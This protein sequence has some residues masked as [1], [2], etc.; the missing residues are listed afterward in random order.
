MVRVTGNS[1]SLRLSILTPP[2]WSVLILP[3]VAVVVTIWPVLQHPEN[4]AFEISWPGAGLWPLRRQMK[5]RAPAG[6]MGTVKVPVYPEEAVT[7]GV[8]VGFEVWVRLPSVW[9]CATPDTLG[10]VAMCAPCEVKRTTT[11]SKRRRI[12]DSR[13]GRLPRCAIIHLLQLRR[14]GSSAPG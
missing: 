4:T 5:A 2:V 3:A 7:V 9:A 6:G 11:T 13:I 14:P 8:A 12:A 10:C 1:A